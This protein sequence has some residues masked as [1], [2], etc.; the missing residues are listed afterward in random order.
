MTFFRLNAPGRKQQQKQTK[1]K[2]KTCVGMINRTDMASALAGYRINLLND[3]EELSILCH[4]VHINSFHTH[5]YLYNAEVFF[6][7]FQTFT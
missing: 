2:Q 1:T 5:I 6:P 4:S 7:R 3:C